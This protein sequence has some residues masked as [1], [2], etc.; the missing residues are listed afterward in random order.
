[1]KQEDPVWKSLQANA[2][3]FRTIWCSLPFWER[4]SHTSFLALN[5]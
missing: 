2:H 4:R 5:P 1:M 3:F